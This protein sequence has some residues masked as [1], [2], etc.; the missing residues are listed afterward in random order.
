M[1]MTKQSEPSAP[2]DPS[3][4]DGFTASE[5]A[6]IGAGV[7][8]VTGVLLAAGVVWVLYWISTEA[9]RMM[10]DAVRAFGTY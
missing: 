2:H 5:R 7:T 10:L 8:V 1:H 6:Q 4:K 9:I 3:C